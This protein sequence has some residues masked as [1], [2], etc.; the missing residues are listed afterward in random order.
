MHDSR[1]F[2]VRRTSPDGRESMLCTHNVSAEAVETD[3]PLLDAAVDVARESDAE[4]LVNRTGSAAASRAKVRLT[5][6]PYAL[7]WSRLRTT[8]K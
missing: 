6:A 5:L 7:A 4:T 1:L 3:F 8:L 2:V